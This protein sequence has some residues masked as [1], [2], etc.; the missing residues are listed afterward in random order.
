M[1]HRPDPIQIITRPSTSVAEDRIQ[2]LG[3]W[4][5]AARR[6]GWR[7][8]PVDQPVDWPAGEC[9]LVD[10]EGLRYLL[11]IGL[12]GRTRAVLL[13]AGQAGPGT[14]GLPAQD[15]AIASRPVLQLTTWAEPVLA[16]G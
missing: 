6:A 9:G 16:E 10:I 1:E 13:P 7:V 3:A 14:A 5:H 15:R 12:R 11:R 8:D 4:V 2:A